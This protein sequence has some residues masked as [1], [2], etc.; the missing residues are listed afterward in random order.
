M[1][2]PTQSSS[3]GSGSATPGPSSNVRNEPP[4]TT[5][6]TPLLGGSSSSSS[7]RSGTQKDSNSRHVEDVPS[8]V[9]IPLARGIA[10]GLSLWLLIFPDSM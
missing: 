2:S 9:H 8:K 7:I 5:E 10:I 6:E 3:P 4:T 1:T